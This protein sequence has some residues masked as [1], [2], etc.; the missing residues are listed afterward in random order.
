MKKGHYNAFF[1]SHGVMRKNTTPP[2]IVICDPS[3]VLHLCPRRSF[4]Y[5][6]DDVYWC[7]RRFEYILQCST[8][9]KKRKNRGRQ[10]GWWQETP[11][12]GTREV[13]G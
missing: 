8:V 7:I 5:L 9:I 10:R 3:T 12:L 11:Q 2:Q 4:T 13:L 1:I 6:N